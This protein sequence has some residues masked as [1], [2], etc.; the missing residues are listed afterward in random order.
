MSVQF[1]AGGPQF[2]GGIPSAQ[3]QQSF[4]KGLEKQSNSQLVN[5]LGQNGLPQ[6]K[7]DTIVNELEKRLKA[8]ANEGAQDANNNDSPEEKRR[9]ELLK[10]LQDGTISSGELMELAGILGVQP[11]Q[12]EQIKGK[13]GGDQGMQPGDIQ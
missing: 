4:A 6:W 12:L 13:G 8:S 1:N 3:Q 5:Q 10:K 9:K 7:K 2:S 11:Q